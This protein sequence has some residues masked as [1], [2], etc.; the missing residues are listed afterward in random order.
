MK[1]NRLGGCFARICGVNIGSSIDML[2]IP[3]G[4]Q[5]DF[6]STNLIFLSQ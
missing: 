4:T 2:A 5:P 3:W 1:G 6:D